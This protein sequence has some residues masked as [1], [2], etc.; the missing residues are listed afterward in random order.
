MNG[1][2]FTSPYFSLLFFVAGIVYAS[3]EHSRPEAGSTRDFS[4]KR[5]TNCKFI[6]NIYLTVVCVSS[7]LTSERETVSRVDE[8]QVSR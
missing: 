7:T 3:L 2:E 5:R 8:S 4:A 6:K 1:T